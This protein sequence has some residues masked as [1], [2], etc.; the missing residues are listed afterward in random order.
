MRGVGLILA[1]CGLDLFADVSGLHVN[2]GK[3]HLILS[4]AA[5]PDRTRLL[6]ILEFQE[7]QLPVR[8]LGLPL[9]L[10]WLSL[11][12]CRP[13]LKKVDDRIQGWDGA[14]LSFAA[15]V[16]LIKYVL[17]TLNTYWAMAF[18]LPKGIIHEIE[19]R[20]RSFLWRGT[21]GHGCP[22]A[23]WDHVCKPIEEGGLGVR[24]ILV[25]NLTMMSRRL[26]EVIQKYFQFHLGPVG[27]L[28]PITR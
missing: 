14:S 18:I 2:P 15:R 6:M 26:W 1:R 5:H 28:G 9:I 7:G 11:A 8:Y 24:D 3:S 21:V 16:Q 27:R 12:D 19:K 23:A 17:M 4:N 20:L 25:F 13:L 22:K 10:S